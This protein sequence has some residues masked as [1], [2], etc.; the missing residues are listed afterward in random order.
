L[1]PRQHGYSAEALEEP[2]TEGVAL[3]DWLG[4]AEMVRL[5]EKEPLAVLEEVADDEP[6]ALALAETEPEPDVDP[7]CVGVAE[8]EGE[9]DAEGEKVAEA[10][11]VPLSDG[12]AEM[13]VLPLL[14]GER[15]ALPECEGLVVM[16]ALPEREPEGDELTLM[17]AENVA[18]PE[19]EDEAEPE[20]VSL[21]V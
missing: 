18:E 2:E 6:L 13:L 20:S 7:L 5:V 12:V 10:E 9:R 17:E 21:A 19:C 3:A 4:D 1:R 14:D 8:C 11:G 15:V 16:V